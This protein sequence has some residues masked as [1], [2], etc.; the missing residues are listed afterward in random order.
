MSYHTVAKIALSLG[1][2]GL[3]DAVYLVVKHYTGG[4]VPCS[5]TGGCDTVLNSQFAVFG[6]VPLAAWGVAYYLMIIVLALFFLQT[7]S[8]GALGL[9]FGLA[10]AGVFSY[11]ILIYVQAYILEAWCAYCLVSAALTTI[12]F[13]SLL[14]SR[15]STS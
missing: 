4:S 2:I 14:F 8:R 10:T 7:R 15:P 1:F 13:V 3:L 12:I 9:I 11:A 6:G 5:L